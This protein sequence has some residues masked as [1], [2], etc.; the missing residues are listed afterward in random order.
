MHT[1]AHRD[2]AC[3]ANS[4]STPAVPSAKKIAREG[5]LRYVND[6]TPG[7]SRKRDHGDFIYID[8]DGETILDN[9]LPARLG[10]CMDL[11][12][13]ERPYPGHWTRC[14]STQTIPLSRAL[15]HRTR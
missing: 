15:A 5:G 2:V 8:S 12:V 11:P 9:T 14:A 1:Q 7:I 13:G 4:G 10:R 3:S 6:D